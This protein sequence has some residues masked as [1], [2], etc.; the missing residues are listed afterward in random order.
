M[1]VTAMNMEVASESSGH[2]VVPM[3]PNVCMTPAAPAPLPMPYPLMGDTSKV[4]LK[5]SNIQIEG[6]GVHSSFCKAGNMKGNEAGAAP[7]NDITVPT[8]NSGYAWS[9]PVPAVTVHFEGKPVT[10]TSSPGF[11]DSM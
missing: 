5:C 11:G 7:P 10:T 9:L 8:V 1:P 3:A 2:Q 4:A 6:K